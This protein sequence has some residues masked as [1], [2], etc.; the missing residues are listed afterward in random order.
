MYYGKSYMHLTTVV[1]F[2][3]KTYTAQKRSST[4]TSPSIKTQPKKQMVRC[5]GILVN[6]SQGYIAKKLQLFHNCST[7]KENTSYHFKILGDIPQILQETLRKNV[8]H[9]FKTMNLDQDVIHAVPL[10]N[11]MKS[12]QLRFLLL[13]VVKIMSKPNKL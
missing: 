5:Q 2:L 9:V 8:F 4:F 10:L 3:V 11:R 6:P 12:S 7:I 13:D 1:R